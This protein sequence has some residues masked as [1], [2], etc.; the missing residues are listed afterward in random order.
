[1]YYDSGRK[2]LDVYFWNSANTRYDV[3]SNT[4]VLSANTWYSVE[5]ET[6]ETAA[7]H[8]EVWLN[9]ASVGSFDGNLVEASPYSNL[10]LT[11]QV[12][13]TVYFDDVAISGTY[14]GLLALG[15][16]SRVLDSWSMDH[17]SSSQGREFNFV[18]PERRRL[19]STTTTM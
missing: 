3:Y 16:N 11:N 7:G 17:H 12:V 10:I 15:G 5:V 8:G 18:F 13:G 2:G 19:F 9:G 6:N 1:M 14:N 4:N